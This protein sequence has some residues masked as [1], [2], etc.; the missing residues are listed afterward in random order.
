[1]KNAIISVLVGVLSMQLTLPDLAVRDYVF[2][3]C[4]VFICTELAL[5]YADYQHAV[6]HRRRK[7]RQWQR[8]Q[9]LLQEMS[10]MRGVMTEY[11]QQIRRMSAQLEQT[12][13]RRPMIGIFTERG[14]KRFLKDA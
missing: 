11:E 14:E 8:E 2:W 13:N 6:R 4:M 1:M 12:G 5:A 3:F 9:Q 7:L 10:R